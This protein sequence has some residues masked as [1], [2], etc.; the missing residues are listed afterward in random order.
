MIERKF[1]P[2]DADEMYRAVKMGWRLNPKQLNRL[3]LLATWR[4]QQ[5]QQ[6]DLPISF[7]AKDNTLMA[8]AQHNPRNVGTM[9]GL[10]GAEVLD[11]RH[12]GKAMLNVLKKQKL[13]RKLSFQKKLFV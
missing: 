7:I 6:R 9:A 1:T 3:K 13:Y 5:A 11:V 8:L 10:E 12:K 2:I 4:Y